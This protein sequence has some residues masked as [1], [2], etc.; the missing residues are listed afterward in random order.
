MSI[1]VKFFASLRERLQ[2]SEV[3]LASASTADEAW[4][5]ATNDAVRP[6]N[7]VVAINL[8]YARFDSPLR[9][10]DEVAFFPPVTGG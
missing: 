8:E 4:C 1:Q 9:D 10:G 7:I 2:L 6:D 5:L 3:E